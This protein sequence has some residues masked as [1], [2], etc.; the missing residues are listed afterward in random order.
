MKL[1]ILYFASLH[2][3]LGCDAEN[4]DPPP[5]IT[6]LG[7]LRQ[8]LAGRG[9][10]WQVLAERDDLRMARNQ[11]VARPESRLMDGDEIAFFP[12]VTGG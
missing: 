1:R 11:K 8:W 5:N 12:P 9:G 10:P 6:T 3:I 7:E 4:I 2:E